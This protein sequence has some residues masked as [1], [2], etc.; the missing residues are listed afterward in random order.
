MSTFAGVQPKDGDQVIMC[1]H[2][3]A[4]I[5]HHFFKLAGIQVGCPDGRLLTPSFLILCDGC[6]IKYP[7][8]PL[9]AAAVDR[10]W[11]GDDPIILE[12][13]VN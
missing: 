1:R 11:V 3:E 5:T 4:V 6:L 9:Y 12:E 13:V 7:D 2:S 10:I 8:N